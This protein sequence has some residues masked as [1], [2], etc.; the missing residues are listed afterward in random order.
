MRMTRIPLLA[1]VCIVTL[2]AAII[3]AGCTPEPDPPP[4]VVPG[5]P[6]TLEAPGIYPVADDRVRAVGVLDWVDLEGG[7]WAI[8]GVAESDEAPST[9]IVVIADPDSLDADLDEL[10]GR[11]VEVSGELLDGVSIRMA[12][13]EISAESIVVLG[14]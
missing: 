14:E 8:V 4:A 11:Y 13:P 2:G 6:P 3:T 7:F 12:G 5:T 10:R 1:F 9:V